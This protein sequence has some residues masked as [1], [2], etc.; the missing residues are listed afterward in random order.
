MPIPYSQLKKPELLSPAGSMESFFAA[1]ENG[2]DAIYFGLNDFSA[3]ACAQNFTL[4]DASKAIA[5]AHGKAVKVYIT[6]NTLIKTHELERVADL[7]VALEELQPDALILQDLGLLYLVRSQF[8]QFNLHAST[9]MTIHNLAGVKQLER[10]GFK[11]VV[12]ARELPVDEI[13]NISGNT[14]IEIEVF[15]HGALCYS[16]SGLCLF[17]SMI[18]GRSGNRGRCA[19]PCRMYYQS[20]PDEGGYLFSMKDLLT[21]PKINDLKSAGVHSFKIEGRMKSPEYVA[22]VTHA[23]RQAIDGRLREEDG[24]IRRLRTVFS[25]ET[26]HAYVFPE[27]YRVTKNGTQYQVKAAD[28]INP[29]YP[30]NVGSYAGEI[31]DTRRGKVVIRADNDIGVRD[32]LQVFDNAQ[33]EPSLLHVKT[34]EIN[35]RRVF[36]IHAGDIATIDSEQRFT[37]GARLYLI[38]SQKVRET[39]RPK[40]PKKLVSTRI[41][42][43]LEVKIRP[44]GISIK[45]ITRHVTLT[46]DY[47]VE[48]ERGIHRVIEDE[49]LRNSFS[50]LGETPFELRNFLTDISEKLFIPLSTL[51]DIRRDF[52]QTLSVSYQK[53][54]EQ[55]SQNIKKWIKEVDMEYRNPCKRFSGE[56][57]VRLSVKIDKLHYLN[58]IPLEKIY[59]IYIVLS[60]ET[61]MVI[62][63]TKKT[64]TAPLLAASSKGS[65]KAVLEKLLSVET[66][67]GSA[68][69][70]DIMNTLLPLQDAIVF[71]LPPIMRDRGNELDTYGNMQKVVQQ[72][73]ALGFRQFQLSNMGALDIFGTKDVQWYADYPIYCLNPL[74]A[75]KLRE[76]GFCRH[77]LS[78]EDDRENLQTLFSADA[79]VIVYQDTPL[80]TSET[81]IWANMKR[82]C[83][84]INLC[85]FKQMKVKNEYGDRFIAMNKGCKTVVIDQKPFSITQFIPDLLEAGL[86]DFRIDLCYQDH[87]PE[88]IEDIFASFQNK[89]K[90]KNSTI[91]NFERGLL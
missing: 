36:E 91:G 32:L 18:G 41:P 58:H 66:A 49:S 25:R 3:R 45:G 1:V 61:L 21:L 16:Y 13:K 56:D 33:A 63:P 78:P 37:P 28:T 87:T 84:G 47:P 71:S 26:T 20:Q 48:L 24:A 70:Y 75:M 73:I 30:A 86:R 9:Q 39:F 40:V 12:L 85:S 5:Y 54:K 55:W 17:S 35:G 68:E 72:L 82:R 64:E 42:V 4:T 27:D 10:M 29:S 57:G 11:R 7:L 59:K 81:C 83:P 67:T 77:A 23:Y 2:A 76:L 52:F 46:K 53:E 14:S 60:N 22:V 80:F 38:S 74:S 43:N 50:R 15:V 65:D 44:H 6:L 90:V 62:E 89:G 51:N 31:I 19:Q 8:P 69:A 88:I 79:D 34:L